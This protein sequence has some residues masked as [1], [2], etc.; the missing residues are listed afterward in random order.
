MELLDGD[1][2]VSQAAGFALRELGPE[3]LRFGLAGF[4]SRHAHVRYNSLTLAVHSDYA[5]KYPKVFIPPLVKLLSDDNADVRYAAAHLLA[6]CNFKDSIAPLREALARETNTQV[7]QQMLED[8]DRLVN[9]PLPANYY[10]RVVL[11]RTKPKPDET[12]EV[13][14]IPAVREK[15]PE[16]GPKPITTTWQLKA[17]AIAG[18]INEGD[19]IT[20]REGVV[21]IISNKY[22]GLVKGNYRL[23]TVRK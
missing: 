1:E 22:S 5:L 4:D 19:T 15:N 9:G 10:E 13:K 23:G 14:L 18:S 20:D 17:D 2:R 11:N 12:A 3:A 6:F 8:L 7:R 16:S 21:W